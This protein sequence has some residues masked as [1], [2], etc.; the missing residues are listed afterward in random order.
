[1]SHCWT[2]RR[3]VAPGEAHRDLCS[4]PRFGRKRLAR[5]AQSDQ[6]NDDG[7]PAKKNEECVG[8]LVLQL[9]QTLA[10]RDANFT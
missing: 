6:Q 3:R 10:A 7:D 9:P 8:Q 1:M 4:A 2:S 5:F